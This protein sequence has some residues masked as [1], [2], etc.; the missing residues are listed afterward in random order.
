VNDY[1]ESHANP[2]SRTGKPSAT[3]DRATP[4]L[5]I[6][7]KEYVGGAFIPGKT[8]EEVD[9]AASTYERHAGFG[10]ASP[11]VG[12]D[13]PVLKAF[14]AFKTERH[15]KMRRIF[16]QVNEELG[17][18][19]LQIDAIGD[20]GDGAE[21][22]VITEYSNVR[23][24]RELQYALAWQGLLANQKAVLPFFKSDDG[25]DV[26]HGI[27]VPS[28]IRVVRD[29]LTSLN[30]EN[31]S[32]Y[33]G[34][35]GVLQ[36]VIF[37]KN[38]ELQNAVDEFSE[39]FHVTPKRR[40]GSG[41]FLGVKSEQQRSDAR[42]IYIATIEEYESLLPERKRVAS[43]RQALTRTIGLGTS[44]RNDGGRSVIGIG[45]LSKKAENA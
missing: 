2:R 26:L 13:L 3:L 39:H 40:I 7:G 45:R 30:I 29:T 21:N 11:N 32:I 41:E 37:D 31:R 33:I 22:S 25:Q 9:A 24:Y 14:Q 23:D 8:Q 43:R 5:V 36:V 4:P 27:S 44:A 1:A 35:S 18:D 10:A 6:D 15:Q 38:R 34:K 28:K 17:L 19:G 12:V 42:K 20:W 16:S